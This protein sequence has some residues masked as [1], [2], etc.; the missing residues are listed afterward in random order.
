MSTEV[1][2]YN[3]AVNNVTRSKLKN[4]RFY[5]DAKADITKLIE[6]YVVEVAKTDTISNDTDKA[7]ITKAKLKEKSIKLNRTKIK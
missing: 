5:L 4:Y 1:D 2:T 3:D 6:K 7:T